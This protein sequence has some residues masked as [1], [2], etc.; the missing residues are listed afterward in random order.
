MTVMDDNHPEWPEELPAIDA[1]MMRLSDDAALLHSKNP[2]DEMAENMLVA[3]QYM[4][5]MAK[6]LEDVRRNF[7]RDDDLPDNLLVRI[8]DILDAV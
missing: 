6:L 2:K 8:D 5:A 4:R 3:E 1:C 7:T